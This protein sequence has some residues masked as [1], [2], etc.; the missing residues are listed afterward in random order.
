VRAAAPACKGE[1]VAVTDRLR[2][3][4]RQAQ[5]RLLALGAREGRARGLWLAAAHGLGACGGLVASGTSAAAELPEDRADLMVHSFNGGGVNAWGPALLIRKNLWGKASVFGTYYADI[6]SNASI[7]VVTTASPYRETRNEFGLGGDYVV[8]DSVI[9]LAASRSMEPDYIA[10]AVNLDVST[11]T[12]GGMTT[13]GLGYTYGWD[14]VGK[15]G[16]GFFDTANHERYRLG[17]SQILSPRWIANANF[18]VVSDNGFLGSPYR[19]ALV[20]GAAVPENLPRT[21]TSRTLQFRVVG[22]VAPT[23]SVRAEYRYFWDNWEVT[24]HTFG[25]GGTTRFGERW[26]VD[27]YARYY[28]QDGALYFS[29]NATVETKYITRNRQLSDFNS[30]TAGAKVTYAI[31]RVPGRYEFFVSGAMEFWNTKFSEFTDVRTGQL[32]SYNA[33]VSQVFVTLLY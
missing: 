33:I 6:V 22:E 8:R 25:I 7:D 19:V 29:N 23:V 24:A 14:D 1:A 27:A 5:M 10:N 12:F 2:H 18:E 28:R 17:V 16:E 13:V 3:A 30:V 21:R 15:K 26:L 9:T 32:Y 4:L 20:F 31:K 11:D